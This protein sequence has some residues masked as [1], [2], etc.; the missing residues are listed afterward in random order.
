MWYNYQ[1]C[2]ISNFKNY[3]IK[4]EASYQN[5]SSH[6]FPRNDMPPFPRFTKKASSGWFG[7]THNNRRLCSVF[8]QKS[9][10]RWQWVVPERGVGK[11]WL[12]SASVADVSLQPL[13]RAA[14]SGTPL[15]FATFAWK[16]NDPPI[17]SHC[18]IRRTQIVYSFRS[19]AG[20][21]LAS[22]TI[23]PNKKSPDTK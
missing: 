9:A 1:N 18:F 15:S 7:I 17:V 14:Q 16:Q 2:E 19:L 5:S 20:G 3:N 6:Q 13:L 23:A 21:L 4:L 11:S 22:D 10:V 12:L 8:G